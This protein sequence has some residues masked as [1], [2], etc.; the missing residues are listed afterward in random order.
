MCQY[1]RLGSGGMLTAGPRI[2]TPNP[3]A[4]AQ[5]P[6]S[7]WPPL[8]SALDMPSSTLFLH[9]TDCHV[10][11]HRSFYVC[12]CVC[13]W[14]YGGF[15]SHLVMCLTL[16][17]PFCPMSMLHLVHITPFPIWAPNQT[18]TK[19]QETKSRARE[20][21]CVAFVSKFSNLL[22]WGQLSD[23]IGEIS[24]KEGKNSIRL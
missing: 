6:D 7:L 24:L 8:S 10:L 11:L 2:S 16:L 9:L 21:L 12:V 23:R 15:L 5:V 22:A 19:S 13:S 4:L 1:G 20:Q 3:W 17:R 14:A 18:G